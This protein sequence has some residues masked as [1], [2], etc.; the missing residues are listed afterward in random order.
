MARASEILFVDPSVSDVETVL[1][2]LRPEVRAIMLDGF[3]P[4]A[5]Q[6]A[7]ALAG[8]RDL[9]AVH[10]IA[11][12]APGRVSFAAG[13]WSA[14]MLEE[15]AGD[16][17]VIGRVLAADGELRLWSCETASGKIG[18]AFVAG[19]ERAVGADIRASKVPV[20]AAAMGGSWEMPIGIGSPLPPLT[21]E[22]VASYTGVLASGDLTLSGQITAS[23]GSNAVN[24]YYLVD[25]TT[26][27]DTVVG[28]FQLPSAQNGVVFDFAITITIPNT[29]DT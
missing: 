7:T 17:A 5:R 19:L 24:T 23:G 15:A 18:E 3:R 20:G 2:N 22:G 27:P 10:I 1:C 16:L 13:E 12:G 6:I 21:S 9:N 4:V 28:A 11:H 26:N 14:A 29:T 8:H 25:T